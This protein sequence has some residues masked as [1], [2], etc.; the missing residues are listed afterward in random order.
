M[1]PRTQHTA[2]LFLLAAVFTIGLTF[3][4]V[5]LPYVID[6]L[7][8]GTLVTPAID[9]HAD[10][11]SRLKTELFIA[12]FN[13]RLIGYVCFALIVIL[14]VAGF[15][16]RKTSLATIGAVG[17]MLPVFAQFAG[18]MFFLAGL[19]LLNAV[20]LPI[21]DIS[22]ELQR[23]GLIIRAPYDLLIWLFR[24]VGLN[25]YWPLVY[26][27][28]GAGLLFFFLGT[29]AWLSA[30][31]RKMGVADFW[32]YRISRHPQYL[33][34]IIWSYG[35]YLLLLRGLYPKRSW[36][37]DASL[38]WLLST[39]VIIG[40]AMM[41]ELNM[42]RRH[43]QAYE[44]Y[45]RSAPFLFPLPG[46]VEDLFA[47]P[48]QALFKK[49]RPDR[50][51]EVAAV[52]SLYAVVL[53]GASAFFYG[54]GLE[55]T[56]ELFTPAQRQEARMKAIATQ[57]VDEPNR[58]AKY[59]IARRLA[60]FGDPAV[61]HFMPL[62]ENEQVEVRILAADFLS[63]LPSE[64]AVPALIAALED[65]VANVR[66]NALTALGVIGSVECVERALKLL[67]DPEPGVRRAAMRLLARLEVEDIVER[68]E[69]PLRDPDTWTRVSTLESLGILGSEKAV[70][71]IV[72]RLH[73]EDAW[74][75]RSAVVALLKIGS[76]RA[77]EGLTRALT[78]ED[79]EVR[80]YA[81]EALERLGPVASGSR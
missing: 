25:A 8:Q 59:F 46:F 80:L 23:L 17:F 54:R 3:A 33:G 72:A 76:P 11:I 51:S 53:I 6:R 62:L 16:T 64:R 47:L 44:S 77:R 48:F 37:I 35:V 58:R 41:E 49:R 15:A 22:F 31:A 34:W 38:P 9:S 18:V 45:R 21:L 27:C 78:D 79:W 1:K 74:V 5:E 57:L 61:D 29:L 40:V 42:R 60:A 36:G 52:L 28:L 24:Q 70:P 65:S 67:D 19:G 30:R 32:V 71:L 43:G 13:L 66:V 75:R 69:E 26:F 20:W 55:R 2:P 4:T 73:D 50:K 10:E 63:R 56:A 7:L 12:H 39:L 68:A 81:D 14:V